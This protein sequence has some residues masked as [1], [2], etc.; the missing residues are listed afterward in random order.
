MLTYKFGKQPK[1]SDYRTLRFGSYLTPAVPPPAPA[2]SVL[3]RVYAGANMTNPTLL[4]PLDG[5]DTL[6]DCTIAAAAH[7][8]TVYDGLAGKANIPAGPAVIAQ[9]EQLTGGQDAG[10]NELDVLKY[11][12]KNA[13]FGG[14]I[15]AFTAIDP[16]NR[17][18]VEQALSLF[19]GVYLGFQVTKD[20]IQ[21]FNDRQPWIPGQLLHEGHAVYAVEYDQNGVTVL[22]WGN[23]QKGTWDWWDQC[24]DEA[25]AIVPPQ[26]QNPAFAPGFDVKQLLADLAAVRGN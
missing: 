23:T 5:N 6:G 2:Y 9:Y 12:R 26:A 8:V 13:M 15:L 17:T 22:T 7:A 24:V 4:F 18:H 11:W 14:A 16:K 10:L 1:K 21:Q 19:G 20:C 25:Y 3:N